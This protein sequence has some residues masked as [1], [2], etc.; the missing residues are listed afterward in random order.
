[1]LALSA[2][3]I[4]QLPP[5]APPL[6]PPLPPPS[7]VSPLPG[8]SIDYLAACFDAERTNQ[9]VGKGINGADYATDTE[10]AY[11]CLTT[12]KEECDGMQRFQVRC[13][14][15]CS[16][17]HSPPQCPRTIVH[18]TGERVAAHRHE[19]LRLHW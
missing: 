3:C 18:R 14:S 7:P 15:S 19:P 17:A 13:L 9:G 1:M 4:S 11:H 8:G 10:A 2:I 16:L 6:S 12:F 5:S